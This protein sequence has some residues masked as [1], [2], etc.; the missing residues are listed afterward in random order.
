MTSHIFNALGALAFRAVMAFILYF[1]YLYLIERIES[2]SIVVAGAQQSLDSRSSLIA[3]DLLESLSL[4]DSSSTPEIPVYLRLD[5]SILG[6]LDP[7]YL[8]DETPIPLPAHASPRRS[9][10]VAKATS[11]PSAPSAPKKAFEPESRPKLR[12]HTRTRQAAP[13]Q[14]PPQAA[15]PRPVKKRKNV[16][17]RTEVDT[18][19]QIYDISDVR[20]YYTSQ[21]KKWN[22]KPIDYNKSH[23]PHDRYVFC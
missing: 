21:T 6:G 3:T 15:T 8:E 1:A 11:I 19:G 20:V 18:Q 9:A 7:I 13:Q 2:P 14:S 23:L 10:R 22:R 12:S 4:E 17:F 5:Y 16:S